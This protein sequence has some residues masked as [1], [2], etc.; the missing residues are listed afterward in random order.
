MEERASRFVLEHLL[1]LDTR[2]QTLWNTADAKAGVVLMVC[3]YVLRH[4]AM[5]EME[6]QVWTLV[7]SHVGLA[8]I[9][10]AAAVACASYMPRD[11]VV[12]SQDKIVKLGNEFTDE[13]L[14]NYIADKTEAIRGNFKNVRVKARRC[15]YAIGVLVVGLVLYMFGEFIAHLPA[16]RPATQ[17]T[18]QHVQVPEDE[19]LPALVQAPE[20]VQGQLSAALVQALRA[21]LTDDGVS[22]TFNAGGIHLAFGNDTSGEEAAGIPIQVELPARVE[23][24]GPCMVALYQHF[25]VHKRGEP[26]EPPPACREF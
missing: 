12:D 7:I 4:A 6:G 19:Q 3:I 24:I 20:N 10:V 23:A 5:A 14:M 26:A 25:Q 15:N 1:T 11:M 9:L 21:L 13:N 18:A 17:E 16:L 2:V 8:L 22:I